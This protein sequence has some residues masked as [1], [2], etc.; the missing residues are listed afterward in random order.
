MHKMQ[1][2]FRECSVLIHLLSAIFFFAIFAALR[3]RPFLL[4]QRRKERK[5]EP[6]K[7]PCTKV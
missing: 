3:E 2:F 5:G 7:L 6:G 1:A 4:T